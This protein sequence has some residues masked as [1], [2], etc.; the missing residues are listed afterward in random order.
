MDE[1]KERIK[2]ELEELRKARD[3][4]RNSK[5][6][7]DEIIKVYESMQLGI[8]KAIKKN[9]NDLSLHAR[10]M[11]EVDDRLKELEQKKLNVD[12]MIG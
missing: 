1:E 5:K 3:S 9:Q 8:I 2:E 10:A 4:V 7:L 6:P 12:V 11:L